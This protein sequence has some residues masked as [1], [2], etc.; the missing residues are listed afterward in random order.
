MRKTTIQRI[1][2]DMSNKATSSRCSSYLVN[3]RECHFVLPFADSSH[4][5]LPLSIYMH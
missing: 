4:M 2:T 3:A 5:P 1:M